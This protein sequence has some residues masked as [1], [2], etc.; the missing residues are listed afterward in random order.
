MKPSEYNP[1]LRCI[2]SFE[3]EDSD[4]CVFEVNV[5]DIVHTWFWN[6]LARCYY[7]DIEKDYCTDYCNLTEEE[8]DEYFELI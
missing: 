4:A 6:S 3:F 8:L 2:K 5:G 7:L 1:R